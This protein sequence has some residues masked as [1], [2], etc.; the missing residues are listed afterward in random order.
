MERFLRNFDFYRKVPADL[1]KATTTGTCISFCGI[2]LLV[3]LFFAE[4]SSFMT[5]R[6]RFEIAM[7]ENSVLDDMLQV[8]LNISLPHLPCKFASIDI[9]DVTHTRR[10]NVTKN[11][12]KWTLTKDGKKRLD[13]VG[14]E[15]EKEGGHEQLPDDHPIHNREKD[16][17]VSLTAHTLDDF[18]NS[19]DVVLVSFFA[20]W[21]HWC[22]LLEPVWENTA[23]EAE[24]QEYHNSVKFAKVDC[25]KNADLCRKH[26]VRAY[27]TILTWQ[28]GKVDLHNMYRGDR[29]TKAFLEHVE[30]VDWVHKRMK[31][32]HFEPPEIKGKVGDGSE[33]C[34][35]EGQLFVKRVPGSIAVT[36]HSEWHNFEADHIDIG[37]TVNHLSF[38]E[39]SRLAPTLMKNTAPLDG[40]EYSEKLDK[41]GLTHH[42][43][44][45]IVE[46]TFRFNSNDPVGAYQFTAHYH[47]YKNVKHER[48]LPQVKLQFDIDPMA[49][50]VTESR[51][52]LYRFLTSICAIIGGVF[53]VL[54]MLDGAIFHGA[55][56]AKK[57]AMGKAD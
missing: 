50:I 15:T 22:R 10:L 41:G 2:F 37:H 38:G 31:D 57:I 42:H 54:G 23:K 5:V 46:T 25:V 6:D 56:L 49:V 51:V 13:E 20:P 36:A 44:L 55:A 47:S 30:H 27:P 18:V 12:R 9:T 21:C 17:A 29:S 40:V 1:T 26:L 16:H 32:G 4:L 33:G 35:V 3:A 52:P 11:L 7:S 24:K 14:E 34:L 8:N 19:N 45:K 28:A 43:Y 48:A 39:L 53:T